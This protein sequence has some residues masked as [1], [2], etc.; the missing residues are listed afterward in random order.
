ME[1]LKNKYVKFF[2]FGLLGLVGLFLVLFVGLLI[3]NSTASE[4]F[5]TSLEPVGYAP[6]YSSKSYDG[7]MMADR[8]MGEMMID[9]YIPP[10]PTPGGYSSELESYETTQY[11][12]SA[13][14]REMDEL[15]D[16]VSGLKADP[17]IHFKYLNESLNNCRATFYVEE[18][19]VAGVLSALESFKNVEITRNTESVTRHREMIQSQT[20]ILTQQLASVERSLIAAEIQFDEIAEFAREAK[21][22]A[23]LSEA[24]RYKLQNIDNLTNRKINLTSQ[25]DNLYQQAADLEERMN[26]VEF[27]VNVYRS[28]PIDN[29]DQSRKWE[30]A[31]DELSDQFTDTL[32]GL[33]AFF[34]IFL[35]WAVRIAVYLLVVIVIIRGLWKFIKLLWSRW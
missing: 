12:V 31:W 22:A 25:L 28:Y 9:E 29:D 13:R 18:N 19:R 10:A 16:T 11:S 7:G 2:G 17:S 32:I 24:I 8:A 23:T 14:T 34:G 33:S 26:I 4:N 20:S 6:S 15:C 5:S 30:A 21:D 27:Y 35:L 1:F 3:F